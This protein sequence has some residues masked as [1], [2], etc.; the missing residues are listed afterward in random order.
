MPTAGDK[1]EDR[2][3]A[4][5]RWAERYSRAG[6]VNRAIAHFGRALDYSRSVAAPNFGTGEVATLLTSLAPA[7]AP[8]VAT[9]ATAAYSLLCT[10]GSQCTA[11]PKAACDLC[12]N[13]GP[14][15]GGNHGAIYHMRDDPNFVVKLFED[16]EL[17]ESEARAMG[18]ML[19]ITRLTNGV[20]RSLQA[21]LVDSKSGPQL[22]IERYKRPMRRYLFNIGTTEADKLR[23]EDKVERRHFKDIL[24]QF[25]ILHGFGI[26][27]GDAHGGNI[28][29]VVKPERRR[30]GT[31]VEPEQRYFVIADP[32]KAR[33]SP[34]SDLVEMQKLS[35]GQADMTAAQYAA[36]RVLY[37]IRA[38]TKQGNSASKSGYKYALNKKIAGLDTTYEV[39]AFM[40]KLNI[41]SRAELSLTEREQA[42]SLIGGLVD[43][44]NEVV[45]LMKRDWA[46]LRLVMQGY[47]QYDEDFKFSDD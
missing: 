38:A 30:L 3:N 15:D 5:I 26:A 7:V 25:R 34:F 12:E 36:L 13:G 44:H 22:V 9:A 24:E 6:K 20:F 16:H 10:P 11:P 43:D 1:P 14:V 37:V 42:A 17:A 28:G 39:L 31:V 46:T 40:D 47:T 18:R 33:E 29:L 45:L 35:D 32:T 8:A 41:G 27:H 2:A 19:E 4:H 23:Y 21:R